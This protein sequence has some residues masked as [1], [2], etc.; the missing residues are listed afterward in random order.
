V[1][2]SGRDAER[3]ADVVGVIVAAG[4]KADFIAADLAGP[5][6]GAAE[7]ASRAVEAVGGRRI[8]RPNRRSSGRRS[9]YRRSVARGR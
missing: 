9:S 5:G 6:A 4:G 1:V 3:G 7:L 2:I 8:R